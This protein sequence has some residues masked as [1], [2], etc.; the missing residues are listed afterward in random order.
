MTNT[1]IA[2]MWERADRMA[3][4]IWNAYVFGV[5]KTQARKDQKSLMVLVAMVK[6][7]GIVYNG[8]Y[9]E[10]IILKL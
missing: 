9:D 6:E 10:Y 1:E 7:C 8:C 3:Q 2:K 5:G 4:N